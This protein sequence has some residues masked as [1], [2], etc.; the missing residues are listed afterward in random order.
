M[1]IG[2]KVEDCDDRL[3][4]ALKAVCAMST[5]HPANQMS[6]RDYNHEAE[7]TNLLEEATL[8]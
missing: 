7:F 6:T 5:C 2:I 4:T 8:N 1:S 3:N